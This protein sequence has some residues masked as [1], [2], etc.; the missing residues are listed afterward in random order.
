LS[1][2]DG[3]VWG[4]YIHGVFDSDGF[5]RRFLEILQLRSGKQEIPLTGGHSYAEWKERQYE[6]LAE[7]VRR[8]TD[9]RRIYDALGL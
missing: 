4:T 3:R 6:L 1:S 2:S 5:R 8:H 9:V 7:H